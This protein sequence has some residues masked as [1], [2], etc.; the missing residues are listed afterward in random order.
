MCTGG[1]LLADFN[2]GTTERPHAL[3]GDV[4]RCL[5]LTSD[6]RW[7]VWA[8]KVA[9]VDGDGFIAL[10]GASYPVD[11]RAECRIGAPHPA[12]QPD[13]TCGFHAV[14]SAGGLFA[15]APRLRNDL[16]PL[17]VALS[18]RV[19][20]FKYLTGGVLFRAERQTVVRR[21]RRRAGE[22]NAFA[23]QRRDDP[24]G[25]VAR[26]LPKRPRDAGP[27]R[28]TLPIA[29]PNFVAIDDDAGFCLMDAAKTR[30]RV[31]SGV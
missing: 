30:E 7:V 19:L 2:A 18:G 28:L 3:P 10:T 12:P 14:S 20:A 24:G 15:F 25:F 27:E 8:H 21:E 9:H 13:C 1:R 4:D 26:L 31:H 5:T 22:G 6:E 17:S 11:A 23:E 16:A 29:L